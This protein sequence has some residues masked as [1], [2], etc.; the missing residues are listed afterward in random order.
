MTRYLILPTTINAWL[1]VSHI[2]FVRRER[3]GG[4]RVH[5]DRFGHRRHHRRHDR[6][7]PALPQEKKKAATRTPH[8]TEV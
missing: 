8:A 6:R 4:E 3:D 2:F 7:L 1:F 5:G